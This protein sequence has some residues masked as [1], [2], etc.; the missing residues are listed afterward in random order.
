M[1]P[2]GFFDRNS[3]LTVLLEHGSSQCAVDVGKT[4]CK[5]LKRLY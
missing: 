2:Y 5:L 1:A 3:I 4:Q